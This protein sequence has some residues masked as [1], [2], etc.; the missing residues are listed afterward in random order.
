M[1]FKKGESGNPKGKPM[2][3]GRMPKISAFF[4]YEEIMQLVEDT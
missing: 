4:S 1:A 2:G 3:A